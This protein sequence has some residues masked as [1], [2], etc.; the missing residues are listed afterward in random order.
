MNADFINRLLNQATIEG[1]E[2]LCRSLDNKDME[3]IALTVV[4]LQPPS[5]TKRLL[6]FCFGEITCRMAETLSEQKIV[7]A[8]H[9]KKEGS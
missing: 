3:D 9:I 5:K 8:I 7:T 6:K 4:R 2:N 1:L